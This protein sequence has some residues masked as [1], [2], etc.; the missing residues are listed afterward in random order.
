MLPDVWILRILHRHFTIRDSDLV[1]NSEQQAS[2][3]GAIEYVVPPGGMEGSIRANAQDVVN[4]EVDY[5]G[6]VALLWTVSEGG[7]VANIAASSM[8]AVSTGEIYNVSSVL[9]YGNN[10]YFTRTVETTSNF[11]V[12]A[13][14][15]YGGDAYDWYDI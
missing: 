6:N 7:S 13:D 3:T 12:S 14:G 5:I 8:S 11:L 15:G 10:A 4:G 9:A 2:I 1:V